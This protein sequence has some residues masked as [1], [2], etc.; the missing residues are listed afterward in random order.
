[1]NTEV[2]LI[3]IFDKSFDYVSIVLGF[4]GVVKV[5]P[6]IKFLWLIT[7][8]RLE[9]VEYMTRDSKGFYTVT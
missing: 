6:T 8:P 3:G 2:L 5:E 7:L 9:K 4:L 1:M